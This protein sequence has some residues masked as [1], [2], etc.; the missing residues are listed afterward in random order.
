MKEADSM[1][2][3]ASVKAIGESVTDS[4]KSENS[5]KF[6]TSGGIVINV[7]ASEGMD[8]DELVEELMIK[9]EKARKKEEEVFA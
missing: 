7:Y 4:N 8:I 3:K 5:S 1:S 6:K 2:I 9:L